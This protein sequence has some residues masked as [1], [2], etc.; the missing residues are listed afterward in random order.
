MHFKVVRGRHQTGRKG[1]CGDLC[2]DE[3]DDENDDDEELEG[4]V[5]VQQPDSLIEAADADVDA[6]TYHH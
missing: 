2:V 6:V 5:E 1:S 4:R 3:D